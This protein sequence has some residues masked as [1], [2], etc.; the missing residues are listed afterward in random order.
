MYMHVSTINEEQLSAYCLPY[1]CTSNT[2][3]MYQWQY[4]DIT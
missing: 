1:S 4:C 2:I 3:A